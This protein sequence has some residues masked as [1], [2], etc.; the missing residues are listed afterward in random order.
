MLKKISIVFWM[1]LILTFSLHAIWLDDFP[2][3]VTQPDGTVVDV[4]YSGDWH[5]NWA[6]DENHFTIIQ[7]PTTGYWCWARTENG[8]MVST[9]FPI[10]RYTPQNLGLTPRQN[11]SEARYRELRESRE[12]QTRD[13]A[14]RAPSIGTVINLTIFIRFADDTE[15]TQTRDFWNSRFNQTGTGVNSM[16]QYFTDASYGQLTVDSPFF[17]TSTNVIV[18][19][20]DS[21]NR[22]FYQPFNAVT[23]PNGYTS[24]N[25]TQRLMDL[26]RDAVNSVST[27]IASQFTASQLDA[28]GDG[29]VDNVCFVVRGGAGNWS[30]LLWS[31]RWSLHGHNVQIL[32]KRVWDYNFNIE[33]HATATN[34]YGVGVLVHEFIH[35]MGAPDFYRYTDTSYNAIGVWC[36]MAST[37]NP[38][39]S[40]SAYV[41]ER[42]MGWIDIPTITTSG[43][44][45]LSP[46][47]TSSTNNAF[48]INS[49]HST[50]EYFIVEYRRNIAGQTDSTL[51]ASGLLVY[52][53]NTNQTNGNMNG[54]PDEL[55][56]YRPGGSLTLNG[57][58]NQAPFSAS[59][60]RTQFNSTTNPSPFLSNGSDGGLHLR[61]IGSAG[62]TITFTVVLPDEPR[63]PPRNL[64][65]DITENRVVLNWEAPEP[66]EEDDYVFK[67]GIFKHHLFTSG[68][69]GINGIGGAGE[70]IVASRFSPQQLIEKQVAGGSLS[71]VDFLMFGGDSASVPFSQTYS[72]R[73]YLTNP[74][75]TPNAPV[76]DQ[77]VRT[78]GTASVAW[79][80]AIINPP[81]NI[82]FDRDLWI[83]LH[84]ST[85]GGNPAV[86]DAG[87]T[88]IEG[89]SNRFWMQSTGW[90]TLSSVTNPP[91]L[92]SWIIEGFAIA[93]TG[94]RVSLSHSNSERRRDVSN[95]EVKSTNISLTNDNDH[96]YSISTTRTFLGYHVYRGTQRLTTSPINQLTFT[97]NGVPNGTHDYKV[98][99][100][101]FSGESA[102]ISQQV[103]I[104]VVL[105]T[106]TDLVAIPTDLSI[107]L[108]WVA[109]TTNPNQVLAGYKVF[110]NNT[111]ITGT[112]TGLTY[113]DTNVVHSSNYNYHVTAVY[114]FPSGESVASNMVMSSL[115]PPVFNPPIDLTADATTET[116]SLIWKAPEN[117]PGYTLAG[118]KVYRDDV[119]ITEVITTLTYND[120][121]VIFGKDYSYHI[122]AV[123][124]SPV[125]ESV[126]SNVAQSTLLPKPIF[127]PPLNLNVL[128]GDAKVLL[129]WEIPIVE[130]HSATLSGFIVYRNSVAITETIEDT[131]YEDTGLINETTYTYYVVAVFRDPI[132]KSEP[133]ESIEATPTKETSENDWVSIF[134]TELIGNYPNP[135]N[136]STIIKFEI[137]NGKFENVR[138]NIYNVRGQHIR[139]LVNGMYNAGEHS[140]VW[141][142]TDDHGRTVSSG[143]YFYR[144]TTDSYASMK[145]MILMK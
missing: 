1:T 82:P 111:A 93:P 12:S 114:T 125:G 52:R 56:V 128:E 74:G 29:R 142:G 84:I 71:E 10:H 41:K 3:T 89:F 59:S 115:L 20:Q 113:N 96:L 145:K 98:T 92:R 78:Y 133:S 31:H 117:R 48:R 5:H 22:S 73:I 21:R 129:S 72:L 139:T 130:E 65:A 86:A 50:T 141:N 38:P 85:T 69:V 4:L 68:S 33:A 61:D 136:P 110:R 11:I 76:Y 131:E 60:G 58:I 13:V 24:S 132:G 35:S 97:N 25:E 49:P 118:Y 138:V 28:D 87:P 43:T 19:Y 44:Y 95:I 140:V 51:P 80:T 137:G 9:G 27:Q 67:G 104:N 53:V 26:L 116:I 105:N 109:P 112:I 106:P 144:M 63:D 70:F 135:F 34:N 83:G 37:T 108:S 79:E 122:T 64:T 6:H 123:Y 134:R 42:Y 77:V 101:Y 62:G 94:Q 15:F 119:A 55:Y 99:A 124:S 100:V 90:T 66:D 30:D 127:N 46:Q 7:D 120:T 45:T 36:V 57:Q 143:I 91:S 18:S 126:A 103:I 75:Q 107:G 16:K 39:Q 54:P 8:I 32:G 40:M 17:P 14:S 88:V 23:N 2:N 81:I 47:A 102:A 121:N